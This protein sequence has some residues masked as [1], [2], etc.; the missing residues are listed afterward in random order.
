V[1][2]PF[3]FNPRQVI[4]ALRLPRAEASSGKSRPDFPLSASGM[5]SA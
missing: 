2:N 5:I 3:R 1:T 4:F